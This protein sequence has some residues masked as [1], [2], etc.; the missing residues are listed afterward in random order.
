M[1]RIVE[2]L[3]GGGFVYTVRGKRQRRVRVERGQAKA[4]QASSEPS[5]S[6]GATRSGRRSRSPGTTDAQA[7]GE[8]SGGASHDEGLVLFEP[9]VEDPS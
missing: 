1:K 8:A 3:P 9:T 2:T 4:D 7:D 6:P 5:G